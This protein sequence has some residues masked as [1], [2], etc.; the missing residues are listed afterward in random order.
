M[1]APARHLTA[2]DAVFGV[3]CDLQSVDSAAKTR[4][5]WESS[6]GYP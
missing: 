4:P 1:T 6:A 2:V 5:P 3:G